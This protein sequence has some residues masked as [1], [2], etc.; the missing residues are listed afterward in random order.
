MLESL[1]WGPRVPDL[2]VL[3][4]L[5]KNLTDVRQRIEAARRRGPHA[6][7]HVELVVVTKSVPRSLF[8]A[9]S[10]AGVRDVGENR[11]QAA[12]ERRPG[13]PGGWTWHGIGHLQ[14]NK[15]AKAVEVFDVFHAL[16]SPRL[17]E[18]LEVVL[19]RS[20]RRWPVYVQVNAAGD[21]RKGGVSP[22]DSTPFAM[23]LAASP[24]LRVLGFMTMAREDADE[25][26]SRAAFRTLRELRDRAVAAWPG[27]APPTG[28]SMGMTDDFEWAVEEGAT[29]VRVG[30]AV[31]E[32]VELREDAVP[33]PRR[34]T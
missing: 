26:E 16:D 31:F 24:T 21:P 13:S 32:G 30:R 27:D 8:S 4:L 34:R 19:E 11:V 10:A 15:S 2:D 28:L 29:V 1:R 14:T 25:A 23:R 6:A 7:A 33:A 12:G 3:D 20:G 9:L 18:R 5:Q 17:A 22:E